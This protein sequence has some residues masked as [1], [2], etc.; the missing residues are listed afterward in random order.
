MQSVVTTA[1]RGWQ[2][3]CSAQASKVD[4]LGGGLWTRS[5]RGVY[6]RGWCVMPRWGAVVA[7]WRT[8]ARAGAG[9][10]GSR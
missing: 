4:G 2:P 1:R 3:L 10:P 7:T 8:C 5:G 6:G 9:V